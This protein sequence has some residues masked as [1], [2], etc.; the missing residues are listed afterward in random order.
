MEEPRS[1]AAAATIAQ[2]MQWLH[3]ALVILL[4]AGLPL[5]VWLDLRYISENTLR[6]ERFGA[7]SLTSVGF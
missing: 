5:A 4:L 7:V 3:V 2:P 1:S 6:H